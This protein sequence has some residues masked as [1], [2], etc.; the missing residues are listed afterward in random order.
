MK[1]TPD[2]FTPTPDPNDPCYAP[3]IEAAD[4][5][6][7]AGSIDLDVPLE[8]LWQAFQC[9]RHWP[10]WNPCF[11]VAWN[12]RLEV[13]G[14]LIWVFQPIKSWMLYKMPAVAR[15]VEVQGSGPRRRVTWKVTMLPGFYARHT[16]HL[17]DLGDGRSRFGSW[18]KAY[19]W[20]FRGLRRFWI[21]H[22][23]FVLQASLDGARELERVYRRDGRVDLPA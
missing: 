15:I 13:G 20:S 9:P 12:P 3:L 5:E 22:F 18:E 19:G 14:F 8:V 21:A 1:A 7:I 4:M 6:P 10:K 11:F 16:Y 23:T 2:R 17:E